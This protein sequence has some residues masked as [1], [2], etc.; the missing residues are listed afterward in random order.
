M[1]IQNE[2]ISF[3]SKHNVK[4]QFPAELPY[5]QKR[6]HDEKSRDESQSDV[7]RFKVEVFITVLDEVIQQFDSRFDKQNM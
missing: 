6:M 3:A 1:R 5:R 7:N 2:S 4:T